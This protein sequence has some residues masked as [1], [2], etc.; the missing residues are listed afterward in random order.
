MKISDIINYMVGNLRYR[1]YFSKFKWVI[2]KNIRD[3]IHYRI[4][5]MNQECY[6]Q[7]SCVECGC[8]TP[9]MQMSSKTCDR[10]CYPPL[11]NKE[12]WERFKSN[13]SVKVGDDR[14][15]LLTAG[16]KQA[17]LYK[18]GE[19]VNSIKNINK[20]FYED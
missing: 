18:N 10:D 3:Q 17:Y 16:K 11:M 4:A 19:D 12:L 15:R 8:S 2:R 1:L 13:L 6:S 5:T 9:A 14:W 20:V 7:G